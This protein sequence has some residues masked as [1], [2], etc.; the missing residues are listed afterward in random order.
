M[1][2]IFRQKGLANVV[3]G[4]IMAATIFAF[5]ITFRPNAQSKTASL[6]EACVAR[7]YGRC[8]DPK[9][10]GAAYRM[11]MPTRSSVVSRK[12]NLKRVALD[13]LVEREL[14]VEEAKRLGIG[15]TDSEVTEQLYSGFVR[16]SVPAA[17]TS[18]ARAVFTE[19]YQG[20]A[21]SGLVKQDVALAHLNERDS[22]IP[23]DFRDPKTK[24]FDIKTYE[25]QVRNLSNRST[26]EFREEQARELVASKMRDVIR[27]PV[28]VSED[29][30]WQEYEKRYTT[31]TVSWIPV[32]EP[33]ASRWV[34][35]QASQADVDAWAKDHAK[36]VDTL[37]EQLAKDDAP[38]AGHIRHILVKVPYGASD[39]EKAAA[40]AKLSWAASRVR[41]GEPFAEVAREMSEDT[42]AGAGGDV[43]D[44]TDK[45]VTP[46]RIAADG[47]KPGA[48]TAGAVATQFGFHVIMKDDPARAA[49]VAAAVKKA[50]PR[51]AFV[52]AK[53]TDAAKLVATRI[54]E[55][56]RAR[57]SAEDAIAK[58][59]ADYPHQGA[60]VVPLKILT[61]PDDAADAG[62]DASTNAETTAPTGPLPAAVFDATTDPDRPKT[63]T[64]SEFNRGG[65]PFPG[66]SPDG[67]T[68][69]LAFVFSGAHDAKPIGETADGGAKASQVMAEPLRITDAFAVV[70][71]KQYKPAARADF[72][73]SRETFVQDRVNEKRDETL[74]LYVRRL[75]D[76]AK[77]SIKVDP[78][79]IQEA[80]ADGGTSESDEE[81]EY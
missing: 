70:E 27:G 55:A 71:L 8:I 52:K 45:F 12:M 41:A 69:I 1:L 34:V 73:K 50:A 29:E 56:M 39:A 46:F 80:H 9:D 59:L 37:A 16:V 65:D 2:D 49:D 5:V 77:E 6:S 20:Y 66:L 3:Y 17:D 68:A 23:V 24:R 7:V 43:G 58:V 32:K 57:K 63:Q 60:K 75:R 67:T 21:R 25:R 30:A 36:E 31:A 4:V 40:L 33:W 19:M 72:E 76:Q 51:S 61:A 81:D 62:A 54:D 44:K 47:L 11:M 48:T 64:S 78:S 53:G 15:A 13:G 74:A 79:Y 18:I 14:L 38:V 22:A 35:G 10:F 28:R 26:T 42:S